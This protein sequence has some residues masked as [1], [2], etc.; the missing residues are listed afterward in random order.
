MASQPCVGGPCLQPSGSPLGA[1]MAG[2]QRNSLTWRC[3]SPAGAISALSEK[4]KRKKKDD[5]LLHTFLRGALERREIFPQA[6]SVTELGKRAART[7]QGLV[8]SLSC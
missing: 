1:G 2:A 3:R 5:A 6:L 7:R 8:G 4:K